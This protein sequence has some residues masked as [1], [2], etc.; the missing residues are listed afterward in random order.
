MY[1]PFHYSWSSWKGKVY[2]TVVY[3]C[4][5]MQ[6]TVATYVLKNFIFLMFDAFCQRFSLVLV[7]YLWIL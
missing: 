5:F 7:L 6:L 1:S 4:V 3:K 2:Y